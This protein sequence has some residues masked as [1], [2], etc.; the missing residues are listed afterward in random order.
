MISECHCRWRQLHYVRAEGTATV[1]CLVA[2]RGVLVCRCCCL[3]NVMRVAE[4]YVLRYYSKLI[5]TIRLS[6]CRTMALFSSLPIE[7]LVEIFGVLDRRSLNRMRLV[8]K[9]HTHC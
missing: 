1:R 4:S 9:N 8:S 6:I 2:R 3:L 7:L 5:I